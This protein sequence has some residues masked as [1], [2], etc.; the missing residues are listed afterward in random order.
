MP[1]S[2]YRITIKAGQSRSDTRKRRLRAAYSEY[3]LLCSSPL[4]ADR[5][6]YPRSLGTLDAQR[7]TRAGLV[8]ISTVN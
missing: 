3:I 2:W 6:R 7:S 1:L 5:S 8:Q 4:L